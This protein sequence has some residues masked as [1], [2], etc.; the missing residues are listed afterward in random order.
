MKPITKK[1]IRFCEEYIKDYHG[2]NAAL[3]SGYGETN[4][5]NAAY[6]NKKN[7]QCIELIKR[8]EKQ[9]YK[10]GDGGEYKCLDCDVYDQSNKEMQETILRLTRTVSSLNY[11]IIHLQREIN[12]CHKERIAVENEHL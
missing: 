6:K 7:P 2:T 8:L 9:N 5:P 12:K 3:R 4:A 11:K 1:Q 10:H